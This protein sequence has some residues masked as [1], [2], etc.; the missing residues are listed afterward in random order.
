MSK[1]WETSKVLHG[2]ETTRAGNVRGWSE[3]LGAGLQILEGGFD[4]RSLLQ[5]LTVDL[6]WKANLID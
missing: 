2:P 4:S 3:R 1:S 6:I 5:E